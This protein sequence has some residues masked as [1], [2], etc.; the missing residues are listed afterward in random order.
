MAPTPP[1]AIPH[2]DRG[3]LLPLFSLFFN[4]LNSGFD[5]PSEGGKIVKR[6]ND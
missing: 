1:E 3:R 4:T 5:K 6:L 2:H